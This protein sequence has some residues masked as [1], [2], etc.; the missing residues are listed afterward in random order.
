[1]IAKPFPTRTGLWGRKPCLPFNYLSKEYLNLV[2]EKIIKK[3]RNGGKD[4][5][6][7]KEIV[8]YGVIFRGYPNTFSF[9][10]PLMLKRI[11]VLNASR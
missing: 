8:F 7:A 1:M 2:N 3:K 5:L 11:I 4:S 10:L 9:R 6:K